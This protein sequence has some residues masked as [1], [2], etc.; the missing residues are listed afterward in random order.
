M[1]FQLR[2]D[3]SVTHGFQR[4]AR[5]ELKSTRG[6][7]G[8]SRP[9]G[10]EPIHE[11]RKSVKKVRAILQLIDDDGG[12]GLGGVEK[13]LRSVSQ[14]LSGLR[15]RD[16]MMETLAQFRARHPQLF[17]EHTFARLHRDLAARKRDA[18]KTAGRKDIWKT[19]DRKLRAVRRDA[20]RWRLEHSGLKAMTRGIRAAHRR[21]RQALKRAKKRQRASDFHTWRKEMK[22]LWYALRLVEESGRYVRRDIR[23][24]HRAETLLGDEHNLVVLCEELSS[25]RTICRGPVEIDRLRLL[26]DRDQ[27]RLREK[28][29]AAVRH[30]YERRSGAYASDVERA[31]KTWHRHTRSGGARGRRRA[32]A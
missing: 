15:D 17:D 1:A 11:A 10:D 3:E 14:T 2:P 6:G 8:K 19:V 9:P 5:K 24:L 7:L 4:L 20:K 29:I 22:A 30:V 21:G 25:D 16:V 12:S 18:I 32:A 31:C 27:C 28:A 13:R 23:A 26:A